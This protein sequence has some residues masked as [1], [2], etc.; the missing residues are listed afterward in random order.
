MNSGRAQ[1]MRSS[2]IVFRLDPEKSA[3]GFTDFFSVCTI[4]RICVAAVSIDVMNNA[5]CGV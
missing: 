4:G 2:Y 5:I 3:Q 1:E